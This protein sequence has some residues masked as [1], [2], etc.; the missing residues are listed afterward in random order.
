[1]CCKVGDGGIECQHWKTC[2][3]ERDRMIDL[4]GEYRHKVDAKGRVALPA[5]FRKV[6]PTDLVVT[7]EPRKECLYV[8]ETEGFNEWIDNFFKGEGGFDQRSKQETA[9]RRVLKSNGKDVEIDGSGRIIIPAA[10]REAVGISKDVVLIGN[11]GHFEIW[12]ADRWD[13][14]KAEVDL[15][16]LFID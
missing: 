10:L 14:A 2:G 13:E 1:M 5:K 11:T 4:I 8:F 12:D 16:V 6:L 7:V 15:S 3:I 9:I